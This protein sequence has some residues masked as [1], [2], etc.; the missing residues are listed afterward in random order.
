MEKF[1][2][3]NTDLKDWHKTNE[4][5]LNSDKFKKFFLK[6]DNNNLTK[7]LKEFKKIHFDQKTNCATRKSSEL[8]LNLISFSFR[9]FSW[10]LSRFNWFK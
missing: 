3:E 4:Q 9:K 10:W 5:T 1:F 6:L 8:S 2:C 7:E